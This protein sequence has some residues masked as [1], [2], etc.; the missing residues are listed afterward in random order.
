MAESSDNAF[1]GY[2][3]AMIE[4][5]R[6]LAIGRANAGK[7][8]LLKRICDSVDDPIVYKPVE[9]V[10]EEG[11]TEIIME[12]VDPSVVNPSDQVYICMGFHELG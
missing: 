12:K 1:K 8:T 3:R 4:R 7:T 2:S 11:K 6:I 10:N 9:H 5:C